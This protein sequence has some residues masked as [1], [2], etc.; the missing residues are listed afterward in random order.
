MKDMMKY[1][2]RYYFRTECSGGIVIADSKEE[3][4]IKIKKMYLEYDHDELVVWE[5]MLDDDYKEE[6]PDILEVY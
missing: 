1:I 6:F 4:E 2:W 5:A 3:A